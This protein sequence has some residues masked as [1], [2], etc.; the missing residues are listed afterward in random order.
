MKLR[1]GAAVVLAGVAAA[2]GAKLNPA[3][4]VV[5]VD[6]GI[7]DDVGRDGVLNGN[8]PLALVILVLAVIEVGLILGIANVTFFGVFLASSEVVGVTGVF[9]DDDPP[10]RALEEKLNPPADFGLSSDE[11]VGVILKV[12]IDFGNWFFASFKFPRK[13]T[14]ETFL[15]YKY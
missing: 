5:V 9:A 11:L 12:G 10:M 6:A 14:R 3:A 4:G 7:P 2:F 15:F 1:A 13:L 8:P